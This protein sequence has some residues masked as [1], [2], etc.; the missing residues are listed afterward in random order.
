MR[1]RVRLKGYNDCSR[2]YAASLHRRSAESS[3]TGDSWSAASCI[4]WFHCPTVAIVPERIDLDEVLIL[5]NLPSAAGSIPEDQV[6]EFVRAG[7]GIERTG[8]GL[9][10]SAMY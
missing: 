3:S 5:N 10:Q 7:Q 6:L 1:R 9:I 2:L 4:G 8:A